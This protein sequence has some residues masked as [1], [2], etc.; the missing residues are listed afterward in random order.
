MRQVVLHGEFEVA[1][2]VGGHAHDGAGAVVGEDVVGDPDGHARA[3]VGID[4][5]AASGH[6]MLFDR[7]QITGFARFL[8]LIEQ[9]I[10]LFASGRGRR[11]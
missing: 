3:I 9:V 10:D 8:L 4:G 7:A 1:L 2:V 6:A 5:E 11:R